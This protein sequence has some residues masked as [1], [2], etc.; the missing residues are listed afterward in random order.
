M[1][2]TYEQDGFSVSVDFT[3][4]QATIA[5]LGVSDARNPQEFLGPVIQ[6]LSEKLQGVPITVDFSRLEYMNSATVAPMVS[7]VRA[8]DA[9][10]QPVLIRFSKDGWQRTHLKCMT[11]IARTLQSVT[12]EART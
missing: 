11:A 4:M 1:R 2:W 3:P 5:W 12:V 9:S 8:L 6:E 7:M 10:G